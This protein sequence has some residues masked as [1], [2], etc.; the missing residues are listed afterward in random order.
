MPWG[1][2]VKFCDFGPNGTFL[3]AGG[4]KT[5][6]VIVPFDLLKDPV[7]T[8]DYSTDGLEAIRIYNGYLYV[9][10]KPLN[11]FDPVKI[12]RHQIN[13]DGS[14]GSQEEVFDM[15]SLN[16][17]SEVTGLAFSESG[18][19]FIA[20]NSA[21]IFYKGIIHPNCVNIYW[22]LNDYLCMING[23]TTT[24]ETWNAYRLIRDLKAHHIINN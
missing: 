8:S 14:I 24:G 19:M 11:S 12:Y 23:N 21:D 1:K 16:D 9:V 10:S 18:K 6:I 20:E 15:N 3:Y 17:S 4:S 5:G 2:V 13:S 7:S 22:G